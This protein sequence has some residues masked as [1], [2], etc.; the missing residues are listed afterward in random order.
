MNLKLLENSA[1]IVGRVFKGCRP[2]CGLILGSG[3]G[4]ALAAFNLRKSMPYSKIPGLGKTNVAGQGGVLHWAEQAGRATLIFQGRQHWY[5]GAGWEPVA[6]PIYLLKSLGA[7]VAVATNAAGGIR[8]DLRRGDLMAIS[9]HINM[10]GANPLWGRPQACWGKRFADQ[11][12]VYDAQLRSILKAVARRNKIPLKAGVYLAVA[13]PTYETPAET[14]AFKKLGAAAVGMSTVPE[15]MLANA[16]G[17]KVVGLSLIS[18]L[19][20]GRAPEPIDHDQVQQAG[21]AASGRLII[22]LKKFWQAMARE[23]V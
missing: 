5:E 19:A 12:A 14:R 21:R 22:L 7:T 15:A 9:D 17:L 23:G 11:S 6:F 13:G 20:A 2:A 18:N 10:M 16:A 8:A 4:A 1:E 3:W